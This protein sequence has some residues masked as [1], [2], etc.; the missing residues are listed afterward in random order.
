MGK[1]IY[2]MTTSID[3]YVADKNGNFDWTKP[4]EEVLAF[5]NDTLG[6]VGTFLLGRS[7]F[8]MLAVW[9]TIP[10]GPSPGMN[11]FAKIWRAENKIVYSTSLENVSI[12]KSTIGHVFDPEAIK[13]MVLESDKDF[14]IGGP[15]LAAKA[16]SV[17]LVDEYHQ[18]IVPLIVGGGT[19]WLPKNVGANLKIVNL[20]KFDN[21]SIHLQYDKISL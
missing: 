20:H 4:S 8:E 6:N 5:V 16:I 2:N 17:D 15:H 10:D 21:G 11:Q 13:K 18:T 14:N 9:D 12:E 7:M 1:L 19:Y 3:G